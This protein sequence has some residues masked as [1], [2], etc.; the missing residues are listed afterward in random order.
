MKNNILPHTSRLGVK[1][2]LMVMGQR[3]EV[4]NHKL[5]KA[6]RAFAVCSSGRKHK[7]GEKTSA[8]V[9]AQVHFSTRT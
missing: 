4:C 2:R 6:K 8:F 7:K 3:E 5:S 1:L 9:S